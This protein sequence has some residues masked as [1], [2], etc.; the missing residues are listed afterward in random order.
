LTHPARSRSDRDQETIQ[1]AKVPRTLHH[2]GGAGFSLGIVG[3]FLEPSERLNHRLGVAESRI[4]VH[5]LS[6]DVELKPLFRQPVGQQDIFKSL[7]RSG[8]EA[9]AMVFESVFF[10]EACPS[11]P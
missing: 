11:H 1:D 2:F 9:G 5:I 7:C 6:F 10:S 3:S 4:I 8:K